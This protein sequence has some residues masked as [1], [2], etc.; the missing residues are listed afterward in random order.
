MIDILWSIAAIVLTCIIATIIT[1]EVSQGARLTR[2]LW[3]RFG[4]G[5]RGGFTAVGRDKGAARLLHRAAWRRNLAENPKN[6][7]G[8]GRKSG[9]KIPTSQ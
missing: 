1:F 4:Y 7:V 6:C 9:S 8:Q 2:A 5:W 3:S